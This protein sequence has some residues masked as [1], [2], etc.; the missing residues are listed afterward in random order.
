MFKKIVPIIS[1]QYE[2]CATP[3][4]DFEAFD[5]SEYELIA[6]NDYEVFINGSIKALKDIKGTLPTHIFAERFERSQWIV[7]YYDTKRPS[8]CKS[9]KD[10][11]EIWYESV[12]DLKSCPL[13]PGVSSFVIV[14][15]NS[16]FGFSGRMEI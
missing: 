2:N 1:E 8:L 4:E 14:D 12:K 9:L 16:I 11:V 7:M 3:E 13:K 15:G 5:L 6:I 10:P